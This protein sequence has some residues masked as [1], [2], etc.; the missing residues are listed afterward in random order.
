MANKS[1]TLFIVDVG[2]SMSAPLRDAAAMPGKTRRDA[3]GV[4]AGKILEANVGM[5]ERPGFTHPRHT[6]AATSD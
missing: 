3:A 2:P 5:N 4:L 1:A 6:W